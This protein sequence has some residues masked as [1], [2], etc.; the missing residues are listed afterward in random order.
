MSGPLVPSL[1]ISKARSQKGTDDSH[2]DCE[3]QPNSGVRSNY[4]KLLINLT[5]RLWLW[6]LDYHEGC[7]KLELVPEYL[8]WEC[9]FEM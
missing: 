9:E 5:V 1:Q 4:A 7:R 6:P 2:Q 8:E 3:L